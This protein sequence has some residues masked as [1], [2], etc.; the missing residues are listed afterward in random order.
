MAKTC[1][2]APLDI[3]SPGGL[4]RRPLSNILDRSREDQNLSQPQGSGLVPAWPYDKREYS[5]LS[6]YA[7][8]VA[9]SGDGRT[10]RMPCSSTI[11]SVHGE[12]GILFDTA[13]LPQAP[14]GPAQ[15]PPDGRQCDRVHPRTRSLHGLRAQLSV[16]PICTSRRAAKRP[17]AKLQTIRSSPTYAAEVAINLVCAVHQTRRPAVSK[18][19]GTGSG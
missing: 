6:S 1:R 7:D 9:R 5:Y 16:R 13:D 4:L 17:P 15:H 14:A 12:T 3:H 19:M 10:C 8:D 11:R 18:S 2:S